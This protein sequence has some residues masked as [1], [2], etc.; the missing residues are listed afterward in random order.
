[1]EHILIPHKRA[2]LLD[3]KTLDKL[4]EALKCRIELSDNDAARHAIHPL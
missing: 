4:R 1:M 2:A 3:A